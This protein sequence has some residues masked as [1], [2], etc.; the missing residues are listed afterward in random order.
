MDRTQFIT[1]VRNILAVFDDASLAI[2]PG[3]VPNIVDVVKIMLAQ[4]KKTISGNR[5]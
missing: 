4:E 5:I 3:D 1:A 2:T